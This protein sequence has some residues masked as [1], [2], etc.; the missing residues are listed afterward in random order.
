M[1]GCDTCFGF[2]SH[3]NAHEWA[4]MPGIVFFILELKHTLEW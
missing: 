3:E 1:H 2:F 4:E